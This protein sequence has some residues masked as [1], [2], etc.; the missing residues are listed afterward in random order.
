MDPVLKLFQGID[1]MLTHNQDVAKGIANGTQATL[2]RVVLKEG[3]SFSTTTVLDDLTSS[4]QIKSVLASQIKHIVLKHKNKKT[5]PQVFQLQPE[6][7]IFTAGLPVQEIKTT[8]SIKATPLPIIVNNATTGHK[9]QGST[10]DT[11]FVYEW[12]KKKNWNY[13]V[14]SRVQTK[15][16]FYARR[17]LPLDTAIYKVPQSLTEMIEWL[18]SMKK[19]SGI[20]I[21]HY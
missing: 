1:V 20:D 2:Q 3:Q 13:V 14:L 19:P 8:V 9:L 6:E 17:K 12:S 5:N 7:F 4:Q 11:I 15:N 21:R 18:E 10:M 16:G